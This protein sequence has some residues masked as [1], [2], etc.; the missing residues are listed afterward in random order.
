[1]LSLL[2]SG[3]KLQKHSVRNVV[4]DTIVHYVED[5]SHIIV[6]T[7]ITD[8]VTIE[9]HKT[10]K[11]VKTVIETYDPQTGNLMQRQS[12]EEK[13]KE[14]SEKTTTVKR[15][16]HTVDSLSVE[17]DNLKM[18][19]CKI[20][21]EKKVKNKTINWFSITDIIILILIIGFLVFKDKIISRFR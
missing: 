14:D 5:T 17:I 8:S 18:S 20:Q 2:T 10:E 9:H 7:H 3:C 21:E 19:L 13:E 1:M 4:N 11:E 15:L 12:T 6:T 16:E